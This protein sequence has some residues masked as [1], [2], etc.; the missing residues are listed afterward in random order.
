L[1]HIVKRHRHLVKMSQHL[2]GLCVGIVHCGRTVIA[3][4]GVRALWKGLTPFAT[5]LTLK[6]ALRMGSNSV[7]QVGWLT[8]QRRRLQ[9][10][11]GGGLRA[12]LGR[13]LRGHRAAASSM[14]AAPT[15]SSRLAVSGA[16]LHHDRRS[17]ETQAAA[18]DVCASVKATAALMPAPP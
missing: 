15:A 12:H 13:G 3:E 7:Y 8:V 9:C 16:G 1:Q 6:Y 4:E 2:P 10:E 14:Q 11:R 18:E 17:Y 5:H